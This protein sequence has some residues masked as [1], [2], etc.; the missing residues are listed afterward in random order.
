VTAELP[1]ID[2]SDVADSRV[3]VVDDNIPS[4]QLVQALLGRAG[5]RSVDAVTEARELLDRYAELAPELILLD[6]H[7]PGVDGYAVLAE[8]RRRATS[9]DL[10]ILVLTADTTR[11]ATHRAL[12]LGA[13]DFLTKPLDA[14]ELV[15]RVRNL[16]QLRALHVGLQRRHRWLEASAELARDLL[17]GD[18]IDPLRR[19]SELA[20]AAADAD[21]AVVAVP[22]APNQ[23]FVPDSDFFTLRAWAGDES[24]DA[25]DL[26][27]A[28]F[29]SRSLTIDAPRILDE[30]GSVN[31][32]A[33]M[34]LGPAMLVPL[35]RA[36][37]MLGALVLCRSRG[38]PSFTDLELELASGF[39]DQVVVAVEFAEARADQERMLVLSDRHRIARDLHDQVI[40]RL[41]ATGLRL[42]QLAARLEPGPLAERLDEHVSELDDT[43]TEI[44]STIFGLRQQLATGPGRLSV[45]LVELASE[46]TEVLGF[47]P[48]LR[49]DDLL[50][51]VSDEIADDLVAAAREAITNVAR[52]AA[53]RHVDV[54]V[55]FADSFVVLVVRD[56]GVGFGNAERRSGLNNLAERA[57]RHGGT[58]VVDP[59]PGGG[60]LV[61]WTANFGRH[62]LRRAE[63]ALEDASPLDEVNGHRPVDEELVRSGIAARQPTGGGSLDLDSDGERAVGTAQP[64]N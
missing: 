27:T 47:E 38:R 20:R 51:T 31:R 28:A 63:S 54:S 30:L 13:N 57:R 46:L 61:E 52:H 4:V 44:R 7:M 11:E 22:S 2:L 58:C 34:A 41:F 64:Y 15:L 55:R 33:P 5:M 16:L 8:L 36:D 18:G 42:Q 9:A 43:I 56:D 39:A 14:T 53:A 49:L 19:V 24:N 26:I 25:A 48:D 10:P 12:Q 6:L 29:E 37:R 1:A 3:V 40:Q 32:G 17:A 23:D 21:F 59:A 35:M 50:D 60:T 62:P 45:R